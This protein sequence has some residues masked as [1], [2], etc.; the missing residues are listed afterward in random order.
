MNFLIEVNNQT[1]AKLKSEFFIQCL[2][3]TLETVENKSLKE[4]EI[5]LSLAI[6]TPEEI[7]K[8]N[9]NYR[10]TDS[11]TDVLSFA[12]YKNR[13][14]LAQATLQ[15]TSQ[16]IFLGEIILCYNDIKEYSQKNKID[17]A[18]ELAKVTAHGLLHLLG[19]QHSKEMFKIQEK[20]AKNYSHE[21]KEKL[22][23]TN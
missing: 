21:K 13:E 4:K 23:L 17:L 18:E 7:K 9:K 11:I 6:V 3:A 10:K 2:Q 14:A 19:Y 8:L 20:I 22:F 12:E 5:S 16:S 1:Q 15:V